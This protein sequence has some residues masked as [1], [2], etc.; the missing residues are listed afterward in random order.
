MHVHDHL[1]LL[2]SLETSQTH[3]YDLRG[4]EKYNNPI[5]TTKT[6]NT[7]DYYLRELIFEEERNENAIENTWDV[8]GP[9]E[10]IRRQEEHVEV[11][12]QIK[13]GEEKGVQGEIQVEEGKDIQRLGVKDLDIYNQRTLFLPSGIVASLKDKYIVGYKF[14]L[15]QFINKSLQTSHISIAFSLMQRKGC[16]SALLKYIKS[17][18]EKGEVK[19]TKLAMLF[20]K[21][22]KVYKKAGSERNRKGGSGN[23][24]ILQVRGRFD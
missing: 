23:P 20:R 17:I 3:L 13:V 9:M 19:T 14:D 22:N 6:L 24:A 8:N 15:V 12:Y 5:L 10:Q 16:K 7:T 21:I 18:I 1:I 2:H 11:S 4:A